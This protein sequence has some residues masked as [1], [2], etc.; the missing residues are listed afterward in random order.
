MEANLSSNLIMSMNDVPVR[1]NLISD[2]ENDVEEEE[3]FTTAEL[4]NVTEQD[5]VSTSLVESGT[6]PGL[7]AAAALVTSRKRQRPYN[8]ELNPSARK[9]QHTRLIRKL[10]QTIHE[11]CT[12]CGQ[13]AIVLCVSPGKENPSFRV[14]G[15]SPLDQVVKNCQGIIFRDLETELQDKLPS[16][17]DGSN[18]LFEL[19][20]LMVEGIPTTIDE[21]NQSQLR[22]FIPEML[23]YSTGRG[24]PGW[25]KESTRPA[26][27]PQDVPWAN[28][29][30]DARNEEAK[31]KVSWTQALRQ[32][33]KNC[34]HYHGREDLLRSINSDRNF[35]TNSSAS[36]QR[37]R[38]GKGVVSPV[39]V[40]PP[41][42]VQT[43]HNADGSVSLVQLDSGQ[44]IATI[45]RDQTGS[46]VA[47]LTNQDTD[48]Q[49]HMDI[50]ME[51]IANA[52]W[53]TGQD[54]NIGAA[55]SVI[56]NVSGDNAE[57]SKLSEQNRIEL[58]FDSNQQ[59]INAAGLTDSVALPSTGE[60]MVQ[61][62]VSVYEKIANSIQGSGGHPTVSISA[63]G[64]IQL[65]PSVINIE[66]KASIK[67][68]K[69][70][71]NV[72]ASST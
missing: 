11:L 54:S 41:T 10:K 68:D 50:S 61:I 63:D 32:I 58:S 44:T 5:H 40:T 53:L 65:Q 17:R 33:V 7:A 66:D 34:Y 19:P 18:E 45:T 2:D 46:A 36:N 69:D 1:L 70:N 51:E 26:W 60:A 55:Y 13:Q 35:K 21:M 6:I 9:R 48:S 22:M 14:F 28:V 3:S 25:G 37:K 42:L 71:I 12:R 39:N 49:T 47:T 62:P 56:T 23:K 24:K 59:I 15:S 52:D 31:L 38:F 64:S 20:S 67:S 43:V 30:K 27:W 72:A 16:Q 8:F 4:L 57:G 29:R